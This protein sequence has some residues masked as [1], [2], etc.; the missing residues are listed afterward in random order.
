ME[1]KLRRFQTRARRVK[2]DGDDFEDFVFECFRVANDERGFAK[3]LGR[4]RD[5]AVDLIDR[6]GDPGIATVAECKFV[7]SGLVKDAAAR[8]QEVYRNLDKHLPTLQA[9]SAKRPDS[10]YR[11]WLDPERP[12]RRYRF[13]VTATMT[14]VELAALEK[15][16]V[17][18]FT[19]LVSAGVEP[20][21]QLAE[22][23]G[24]VRVFSWDWFDA[25]LNENPT[26]AFRWF[27]NLPVG[28]EL[29]EPEPNI[30]ATFRDFL[31]G[32]ELPFFSR[33]QYEREGVGAVEKGEAELVSG[34]ADGS[35]SALLLSGPGGVGKTRLSW[36]LATALA[37][38]NGFQVYRLG[39]S[40]SFDSVIAL[41]SSYVG[42]ALILLV[43][44]Y[45]EA[46]R[47]LAGIADAVAQ[48]SATTE[49]EL[50]LVL[51]CR[52]SS[53][54]QVSDDLAVL[55]PK[56][57]ELGSSRAGEDAYSHWV[58]LSILK[59]A[60]FPNRDQLERVCHGVPALAAFALFLFRHHPQQFDAQFGALHSLDDF[61][62]WA[63]HRIAILISN[64][65]DR[66]A[67]ERM[68]ARIALALPI[69]RDMLNARLGSH[70]DLLEVLI[71]DRW[72][73]VSHDQYQ[74]AHDV[75]ADALAARWLF[76]VSHATT[77]HAIELLDDAAQQE[78]LLQTII[79]LER[80]ASHRKFNEING[81]E[82]ISYLLQ[83]Y[84]EQVKRSC[85]GWFTGSLL[86]VED[87]VELLANSELMRET[88]RN[89]VF[90]I[91]LSHLSA[92]AGRRKLDCRMPGGAIL[93][94]LLDPVCNRLT[95]SNI[96]L[97]WAYAFDPDRF[98]E[99]A[100]A[101]LA[102]HAQTGST[103]FLLVQ[104]LKSGES[105]EKL[106]SQVEAWLEKR[107]RE[108]RASFLYR[109]WL[110]HGGGGEIIEEALVAWV[111]LHAEAPEA[112]YIYGEWLDAGGDFDRI[113]DN[114][115]LWTRKWRHSP[116]LTYLNK[117]L[118]RRRDLP[119]DILTIIAEWCEAHPIDDDT[120]GRLSSLVG[121]LAE[122]TLTEPGRRLLVSIEFV[123]RAIL[124]KDVLTKS[125][126]QYLWSTCISLS[127]N[128]NFA[129]YSVVRIA[130][131]II[132][133]GRVF[134]NGR[135]AEYYVPLDL[136]RRIIAQIVLCCLRF[137]E[138]DLLRDSEALARFVE[139]FRRSDPIE[140]PVGFLGRLRSEFPSP[141][142]I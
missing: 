94:E 91:S 2:N 31:S 83:R 109:A 18:D 47:G 139:W 140:F 68:L 128:F 71:V 81:W 77:E 66:R 3:H 33:D 42:P 120:L 58:T 119:D 70:A 49:H 117:A 97:R 46:V 9:D 19:K 37:H 26:L 75:F 116:D 88:I 65:G 131:I 84:P 21:R 122:R 113:K 137:G 87:K 5:G 12:V 105:H 13:C 107:S 141:V 11:S 127:N 136:R 24:A 29:F 115:Y 134:V 86:S 72:I 95:S 69:P 102:A 40:A 44:D 103:D 114:I 110:K 53:L 130:A 15:R 34:L 62:K 50:R 90:D 78:E 125:D 64:L 99:R 89:P 41:A 4:G 133:S 45:A 111:E 17:D 126:E 48:V 106:R 63:N 16:I 132:A 51:T 73:E 56:V 57:L 20:L 7:G 79:A 135:G 104:M 55:D 23:K 10:P 14:K 32:G 124:D 39:R 59:L 67:N 54:N 118:C 142:W 98:R 22:E 52:A 82:L 43:I 121:R 112:S 100:F 76:E 129:P 35:S 27:G 8:W 92:Q 93:S 30:E 61:E 108:S 80:L 38:E 36:E 74:A 25:E 138:L 101:W 85:G 60:S 96:T 6:F 123:I 1:G 28:I